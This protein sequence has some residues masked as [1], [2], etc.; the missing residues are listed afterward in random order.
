[1][2]GLELVSGL[3]AGAGSDVGLG[4]ST[5]VGTAVGV[6]VDP[7]VSTAGGL[8]NA[9]AEEVDDIVLD[10]EKL[11]DNSCVLGVVPVGSGEVADALAEEAVLDME[12]L[13]DGSCIL[14]VAP[15]GRNQNRRLQNPLIIRAS[16]IPRASTAFMAKGA[17]QSG[18]QINF[19]S[20]VVF[21]Y[22]AALY[23]RRFWMA[24][25]KRVLT[26]QLPLYTR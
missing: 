19:Q 7:D 18:S 20:S 15:V 25:Q 11:S 5:A 13:A 17:S 16:A 22:P 12:L 26:F 23:Q 8:I 9:L 2:F 3:D 6:D 1:M 14:E 24:C 4:G 10:V 21:E